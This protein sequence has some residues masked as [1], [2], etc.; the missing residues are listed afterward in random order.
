M[1]Y[2]K[3]YIFYSYKLYDSLVNCL[4]E[5]PNNKSQRVYAFNAF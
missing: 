2:K 5:L 4:E 3:Y 1:C